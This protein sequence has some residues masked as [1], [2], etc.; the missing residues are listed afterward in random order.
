[1]TR[2]VRCFLRNRRR[3]LLGRRSDAASPDSGYRDVP[4]GRV[5]GTDP[6]VGTAGRRLLREAFGS[7]TGDFEFVRAGRPLPEGD[8]AADAVL[9]V[10]FETD[11]RPGTAEGAFDDVE[12]VDPTAIR[13]RETAPGLWTAWRRVAPTVET[14]RQDRTHG[15]AWIAARALEVLRDAATEAETWET[16]AAVARDLRTAR[17]EMAAV[18]NAVDRAVA[19]AEPVPAEP[20]AVV[21]CAVTVLDAVLAAGD[22]AAQAAVG[23]LGDADATAVAT[24]SRSGTVRTALASLSPDRLVVAESRPEREGVGV[25]ERAATDTDAA[26]TLTTEAGLPTALTEVDVDAALVGADAVTPAGDVVNKTGT[27]ILALAAR[28]AGVP[29]YVVASTLKIRPAD[30]GESVPEQPSPPEAV[31]DGDADVSVHAPTFE[32]VPGALVDGVATEEGVLDADGI[33]AAAEAHA[34]NAAWTEQVS[35]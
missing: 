15:S 27:R 23:R 6:S 11:T 18:A 3:V 17:P 24:L 9:P 30:G 28:D 10:L 14:V 35:E 16:V 7:E 5:D 8:G 13:T 34:D 1:M 33:R 20:D 25:A 26:V 2:V 22:G 12:W 31:Y 4:S 29:T 19:A 32:T 21:D